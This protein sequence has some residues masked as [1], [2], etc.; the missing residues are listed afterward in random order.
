MLSAVNAEVTWGPIRALVASGRA[1]VSVP[2]LTFIL[3]VNKLHLI[4]HFAP[5]QIKYPR[6]SIPST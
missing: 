4:C 5:G 6:F 2:I 1:T 3:R